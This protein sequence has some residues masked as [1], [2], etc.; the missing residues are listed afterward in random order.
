M[1]KST[2]GSSFD[3][4]F[5]SSQTE[6]SR[7]EPSDESA[8]DDARYVKM[9]NGIYVER[10]KVQEYI[11]SLEDETDLD[12]PIQSKDIFVGGALGLLATGLAIGSYRAYKNRRKGDS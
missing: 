4:V 12:S 2:E 1:H 8:F 11:D 3:E 6:T 9:S 10:D 7:V 5:V